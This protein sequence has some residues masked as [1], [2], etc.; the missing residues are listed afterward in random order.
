MIL[1]V[2]FS[3]PVSN[4]QDFQEFFEHPYQK[5][6]VNIQNSNGKTSYFAQMFTQ[7]QVFAFPTC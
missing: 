4:I 3:K 1:S 2:T 5:I 7:T 6:K